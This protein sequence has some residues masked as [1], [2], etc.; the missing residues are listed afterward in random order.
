MSS[1]A[2]DKFQAS[3]VASVKWMTNLLNIVQLS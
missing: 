3:N 2:I 1:Y